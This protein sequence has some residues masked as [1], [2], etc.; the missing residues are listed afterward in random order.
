M[1]HSSQISAHNKKYLS[2]ACYHLNLKVSQ[3][4]TGCI[5][6]T[7]V[8]ADRI[9]IYLCCLFTFASLMILDVP[10]KM[11]LF[12]NDAD[13]SNYNDKL[14][15]QLNCIFSKCQKTSQATHLEQQPKMI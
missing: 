1:I 6:G 11:M 14:K 12:H 15:M 5:R 7:I 3:Q 2:I 10:P 4:K 8:L 13:S 9:E